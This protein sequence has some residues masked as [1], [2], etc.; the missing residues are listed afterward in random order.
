MVHLT[1]P[2]IL[3]R[4]SLL[5]FSAGL[6]LGKY[7]LEPIEEKEK[8]KKRKKVFFGR[9]MFGSDRHDVSWTCSLLELGLNVPK[10]M[11]AKSTQALSS[12]KKL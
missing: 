9:A 2:F 10:N 4:P 12:D 7:E 1:T 11:K 5:P 6:A 3:T 8:K